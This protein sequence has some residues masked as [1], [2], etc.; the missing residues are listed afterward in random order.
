MTAAQESCVICAYGTVERL[1]TQNTADILL[2]VLGML[3]G[4]VIGAVLA[5][6][7]IMALED[8]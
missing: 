2:F 5:A 8:N 1:Q 6:C 4:V 3:T 7:F